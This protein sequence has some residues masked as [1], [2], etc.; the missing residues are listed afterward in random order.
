[1]QTTLLRKRLRIRASLTPMERHQS[2][3]RKLVKDIQNRREKAEKSNSDF[4][5]NLKHVFSCEMDYFKSICNPET[6][7]KEVK[8]ED[9]SNVIVTE[10]Y[11]EDIQ[12]L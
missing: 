7:T 11:E 3:V 9:Q 6:K 8:P 10:S 2:N 4:I 1:M 12:S 5:M